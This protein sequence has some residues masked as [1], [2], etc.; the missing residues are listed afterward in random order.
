MLLTHLPP[1]S[2][3]LL[4]PVGP[5]RSIH[6]ADADADDGT[7]GP[8]SGDSP[9]LSSPAPSPAMCARCR[10]VV[11]ERANCRLLATKTSDTN[12]TGRGA[13]RAR[14]G[15]SNSRGGGGL[16]GGA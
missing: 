10:H 12:G 1:P 3:T 6:D 2:P 11:R 15:L 7:S 9:T 13:R 8:A 4:C 14:A 5:F 16:R